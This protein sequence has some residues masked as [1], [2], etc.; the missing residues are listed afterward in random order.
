MTPRITAG[1]AA[2]FSGTLRACVRIT[3]RPL[4]NAGSR[5]RCVGVS[6]LPQ[7]RGPVKRHRPVDLTT[8][9]APGFQTST[10]EHPSNPP[11][12]WRAEPA[13]QQ[14]SGAGSDGTGCP[15]A[16]CDLRSTNCSR[17]VLRTIPADRTRARSSTST[18]Q[19]LHRNRPFGR[20]SKGVAW[21]KDSLTSAPLGG[22]WTLAPTG[23]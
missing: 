17:P 7:R 5:R 9:F 21:R 8:N 11:N 16:S 14:G 3:T 2:A 1:S 13:L 23:S 19:A 15:G 20:F 18:G 22:C 12:R 4:R 6:I 10:R